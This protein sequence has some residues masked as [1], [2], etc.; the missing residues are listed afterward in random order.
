MYCS[1]CGRQ[2][3]DSQPFCRFCGTRL[4]PTA[5][6]TRSAA[7]PNPTVDQSLQRVTS[8]PSR[9]RQLLESIPVQLVDV[10]PRK[11]PYIRCKVC[12]QGVLT[13]KRVFRMSTPVVVI[14]YIF[15]IPS[16]LGIALA[17]IFVSSSATSRSGLTGAFAILFGIGCFVGG[18]FGWLLVMKKRVLRCS[19]CGATLD[20]S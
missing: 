5:D 12:E 4:A 9:A 13:S 15:L 1:H 10:V 17:L 3:P 16:F 14:G 20:A 18:L 8:Q 19:V 2:N 11:E 6:R 7:R